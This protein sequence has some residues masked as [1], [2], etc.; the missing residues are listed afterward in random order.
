MECCY[1]WTRLVKQVEGSR[2]VWLLPVFS[3]LTIFTGL[4][5]MPRSASGH[6]MML[7]STPIAEQASRVLRNSPE[8]YAYISAHS[9]KLNE[10]RLLLLWMLEPSLLYQREPTPKWPLPCPVSEHPEHH[11]QEKRLRRPNSL[12]LREP[13]SVQRRLGELKQRRLYVRNSSTKKYAA[14]FYRIGVTFL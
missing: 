6:T 9:W 14:Q 10:T 13:R 11:T 8:R 12:L 3:V 7:A 4:Q 1:T 5:R 2:E